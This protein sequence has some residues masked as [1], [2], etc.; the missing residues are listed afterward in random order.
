MNRLAVQQNGA[1]AWLVE[2]GQA[3]EDCGLAR[4]VGADHRHDLTF[5]DGQGHAVNR[6]Q[7]AKTH[8]QACGLQ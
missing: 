5:V 6:Q 8:A 3:V 7:A 1:G 2:A 4:A